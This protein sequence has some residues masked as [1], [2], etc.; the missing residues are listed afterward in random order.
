MPSLTNSILFDLM[1]ASI[2]NTDMRLFGFQ[3]I[4]LN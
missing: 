3:A 1:P 4:S 2:Q